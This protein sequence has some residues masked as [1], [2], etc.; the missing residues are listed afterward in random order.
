MQMDGGMAWWRKRMAGHFWNSVGDSGI[1]GYMVFSFNVNQLISLF[2][3]QIGKI[4]FTG[5]YSICLTFFVMFEKL[6]FFREYHLLS[7]LPFKNI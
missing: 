5:N 4:V 7:C 1:M 6:N 3:L 2:L